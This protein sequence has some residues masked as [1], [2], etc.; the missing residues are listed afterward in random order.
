MTPRGLLSSYQCFGGACCIHL[1][2]SSKKRQQVSKYQL[3]LTKPY[4]IIS[5]R[6]ESLSAPLSESHIL[7]C[8]ILLPCSISVVSKLMNFLQNYVW[9]KLCL[10]IRNLFD[11][12][13]LTKKR[14]ALLLNMVVLPL[15]CVWHWF[16][17]PTSCQMLDTTVS[18]LGYCKRPLSLPC[19]NVVCVLVC[20]CVC[21]F[22]HGRMWCRNF[23]R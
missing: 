22:M 12:V 3:L 19:L 7:H 14:L 16:I 6:F 17:S 10:Q 8:G 5:R 18:H 23:L 15:C 4:S 20:V 11:I 21:V 13:Y 9:R 1:S 2:G